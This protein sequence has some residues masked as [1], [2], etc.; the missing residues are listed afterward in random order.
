MAMLVDNEKMTTAHSAI[1]DASKDFK[2][3]AT[4]FIS[5]LTTA[6]STFEGDTKDALM[7][8]KIGATGS[9]VEGTLAYFVE[10][11]IPQ[12]L[13]GLA[14]LLDG[15]RQTI[16]ETDQKLAEAIRTGGEG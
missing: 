13:D 1:Q 8:K 11:Q 2:N 6:L 5:D 12:L 3:K 16:D 4:A 9:E 15:N 14:S 7:E 10:T